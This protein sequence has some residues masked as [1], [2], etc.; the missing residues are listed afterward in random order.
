MKNE[1]IEK[2]AAND[3]RLRS[4][5]DDL[6]EEEK[7]SDRKE[8]REILAIID[9]YIASEIKAMAHREVETLKQLRENLEDINLNLKY[10]NTR[11]NW[12]LEKEKHEFAIDM[13]E[14][15]MGLKNGN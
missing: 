13:L 3:H 12:E 8:A 6:S 4:R 7:D 14:G 9:D 15:M 11:V 1:I 5:W 10:D 2:L